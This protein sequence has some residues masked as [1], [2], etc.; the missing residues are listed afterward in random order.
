[1]IISGIRTTTLH[2]GADL[3]TAGRHAQVNGEATSLEIFGLGPGSES[4]VPF[5]CVARQLAW[6]SNSAGVATIMRLVIN[7]VPSA[8]ITLTGTEGVV[9]INFSI[10][11]AAQVAL[12]FQ[13]GAPVPGLS[14]WIVQCIGGSG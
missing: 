13:G 12:E 11:A 14:T 8:D 6:D 10:P 3:F 2:Y 9:Q 5:S 4:T 7:G 1:M